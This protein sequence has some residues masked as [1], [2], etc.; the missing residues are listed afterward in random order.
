MGRGGKSPGPSWTVLPDGTQIWVVF[1][2]WSNLW[3]DTEMSSS[4][5][6]DSQNTRD[7]LFSTHSRIS[8]R[9]GNQRLPHSNTTSSAQRP[10]AAT[11]AVGSVS[12]S[13]GRG[14]SLGHL[15]STIIR[16]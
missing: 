13:A 16:H 5:E 1:H 8:S 12:S 15:K 9:T 3:L 6:E 11:S 7:E 14:E 2:V 4:S 10:I